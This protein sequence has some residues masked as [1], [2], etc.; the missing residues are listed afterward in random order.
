MYACMYIYVCMH[1]HVC[2]S[3]HDDH[4]HHCPSHLIIRTH[5]LI[6]SVRYATLVSLPIPVSA[7]KLAPG[8]HHTSLATPIGPLYPQNAQY[9]ST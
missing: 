7:T 2:M 8:H 5:Q 6:D 4:S 1:A 9:T 3:T